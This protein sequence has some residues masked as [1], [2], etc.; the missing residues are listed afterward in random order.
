MCEPVL[1]I[2]GVVMLATH[3]SPSTAL[4]AFGMVYHSSR[5]ENATRISS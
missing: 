1:V 3:L 5:V 4:E 2:D